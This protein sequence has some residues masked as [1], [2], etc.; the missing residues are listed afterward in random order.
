MPVT[1]PDDF[2]TH[3]LITTHD[4]VLYNDISWAERAFF[5]VGVPGGFVLDTGL[6][7]YPNND[8]LEAYAV[9][10]VSDKQYN[11]RA[12][13]S[14]KSGRWNKDVGPFEFVTVDPLKVWEIHLR[15]N[16]IGITLDLRFV[17]RAAP[18]ECRSPFLRKQGRLMY[19][20]VNFFQSG[21]FSGTVS[22]RGQTF[23]VDGQA[24]HRDRTWGI[25]NSGEGTVPRGLLT[26]VSA[27]FSDHSIMAII[28]E[29]ANGKHAH[30]AGAISYEDGRVLNI[31]EFEHDLSFEPGS[32]RFVRGEYK[33]TDETGKV[34]RIEAERERTLYL[35]GAG[36]TSNE[37]RRGLQ[38]GEYWEWAELWDQKNPSQYPEYD[39]LMDN[40]SR[41]RCESRDGHGIVET[42]LGEHYRYLPRATAPAEKS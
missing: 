5:T 34:W 19:D 22:V 37:L 1:K 3:Q 7:F 40:F 28:Y 36:Y 14:L 8:V 13:R 24:G 23:N 31:E 2:F 25:R 27:E 29:R 9:A 32:K 26:W 20:N 35:S 6:S 39:G 11:I 30:A 38:R 21:R 33:F 10:A 12:S 42:L 41:F 4:H 16:K 17:S 15:E 18:I